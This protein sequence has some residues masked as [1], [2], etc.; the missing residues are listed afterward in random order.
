MEDKQM[1][2]QFLI[3]DMSGGILVG[4]VMKK[5]LQERADVTYDCKT[6]HGI[7][8]F[9]K[10][11]SVKEV[12]T[13]KLLND[14]PIFLRAF[15]S[16]LNVDGYHAALIIVLDNDRNDPNQFRQQLESLANSLMISIDHV[17][18]IAVEEMEAWL[19]GDRAAVLKAYPSA[20]VNILNGYVQDSICG[21]WEQLAAAIYPGGWDKFCKNCRSYQDIGAQKCEWALNIG[22]YMDIHRNNSPSFTNFIQT[23]E[24]RLPA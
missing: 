1:H 20:K 22:T 19:L 4:E 12:K 15:D 23:I 24:T 5:L 16:S 6:F 2:F 18:C 10:K 3:E 13:Q 9:K 8:G 7:G 17:F 11:C 21:T 14:L